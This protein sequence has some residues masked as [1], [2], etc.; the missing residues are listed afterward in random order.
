MD[1]EPMVPFATP[2]HTFELMMAKMEKGGVGV[3]LATGF[4]IYLNYFSCSRYTTLNYELGFS[5]P[6]KSWKNRSCGATGLGSYLSR[7]VSCVGAETA[8]NYELGFSIP[9]KS[10][11]LL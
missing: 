9:Q 10:W 3:G 7:A 11:T 1:P 5:T 2:L 6:Q 4:H 8:Q